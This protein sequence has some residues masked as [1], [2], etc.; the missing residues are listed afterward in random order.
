V[1]LRVFVCQQD[2]MSCLNIV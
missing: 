2:E 1:P